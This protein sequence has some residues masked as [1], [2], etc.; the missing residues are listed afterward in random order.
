MW[1]QVPTVF[2]SYD[3]LKPYARAGVSVKIPVKVTYVWQ[4]DG[5]DAPKKVLARLHPYN[6]YTPL[7]EARQLSYDQL[8]KRETMCEQTGQDEYFFNTAQLVTF[9]NNDF[10]ELNDRE[11]KE[12][13]MTIT[14]PEDLPERLL[15]DIIP[16]T[17]S[18]EVRPDGVGAKPLYVRIG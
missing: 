6:C 9:S 2:L 11:V 4:D 17:A 14:I 3:N 18:A 5:Y 7:K 15:Y 12:M 10:F 8:K 1:E 16:V 13:F